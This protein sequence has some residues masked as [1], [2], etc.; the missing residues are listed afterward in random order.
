MVKIVVFDFS[1]REISSVPMYIPSSFATKFFSLALIL[2]FFTRA[3]QPV[4]AVSIRDRRHFPTVPE[5]PPNRNVSVPNPS[6]AAA[7]KNDHGKL[8]YNFIRH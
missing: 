1:K 6:I 2:F 5:T 7:E 4:N 3:L 8:V